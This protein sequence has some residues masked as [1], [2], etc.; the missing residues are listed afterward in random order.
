VLEWNFSVGNFS[1]VRGAIARRR[2]EVLRERHR[3]A[4]VIQKYARRQAACRKYQS[5][6][7]KVLY[8]QAGNISFSPKYLCDSLALC[9]TAIPIKYYR[10]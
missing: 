7:E 6:K 8:V 1:V 4:I 9:A 5:A 2:F 3:A 10:V